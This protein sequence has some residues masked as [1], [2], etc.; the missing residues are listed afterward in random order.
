M[1]AATCS[2]CHGAGELPDGKECPRCDGS[3]LLDVDCWATRP[4]QRELHDLEQCSH[5]AG[6]RP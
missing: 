2:R 5:Y 6:V 4:G 1:T 3:G